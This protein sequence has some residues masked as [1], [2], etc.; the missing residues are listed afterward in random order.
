MIRLRP[1]HVRTR[2]TLWYVAVLAGVLM[3]YVT[4]L[5][6]SFFS[7]FAKSWTATPFK[8]LKPSSVF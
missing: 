2:L 8:I 4:A 5:R 1:R 7:V 3:L 6:L